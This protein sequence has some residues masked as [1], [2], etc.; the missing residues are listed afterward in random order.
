[1]EMNMKKKTVFL[2]ALALLSFSTVRVMAT[3]V[4]V[5]APTA[6]VIVDGDV[7][8]LSSDIKPIGDSTGLFSLNTQLTVD[9]NSIMVSAVMG[10]DPFISFGATSTNLG[11]GPTTYTFM[12]GT[13]IVPGFYQGATSSAGV[14]VTNTSAA[15]SSVSNNGTAA[16]VTGFGTV[17]AASTNLGVDLGSGAVTATGNPGSTTQPFG[18]GVS[19][20]APTFYNNLEAVLTYTQT[21]TN[22]VASWSGAV[23]LVPVP[24]P[25]SVTML[26]IGTLL[27]GAAGA[28]RRRMA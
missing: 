17:G 3:A 12:F 7:V 13:P 26:G 19:S 10:T 1:M 14:T 16:Y 21:G 22:G 28:L 11:P 27:V 25:T 4:P 23:S 6:M 8:D 15:S 9:G 18:P 2:V 5:T 20:F 24:E